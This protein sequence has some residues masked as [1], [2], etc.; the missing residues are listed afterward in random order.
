MGAKIFVLKRQKIIRSAMTES[1]LLQTAEPLQSHVKA[2]S[3]HTLLQHLEVAEL[4]GK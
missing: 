2:Y 1:K 4:W 3:L